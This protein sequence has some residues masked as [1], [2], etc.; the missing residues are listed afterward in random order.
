MRHLF[1]Y[2]TLMSPDVMRAVAGCER[3]AEPAGLSG[4]RRY[5]VKGADFPAIIASPGAQLIGQL[6]RNL[7]PLA[8]VRL[9]RFEG[10][11]YARETRSVTL[12]NDVELAVEVYVLQPGYRNC[13]AANDWDFDRFVATARHRYLKK[14]RRP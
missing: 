1:T 7:P 6:Y 4:F 13:L 2:G 10:D 3:Q 12:Q 5:A 14:F 11:M 8:W 9:D